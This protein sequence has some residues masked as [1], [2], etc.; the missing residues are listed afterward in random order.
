M[1]DKQ[2]FKLLSFAIIIEIFFALGSNNIMFSIIG[3]CVLLTTAIFFKPFDTLLIITFLLPNQRLL[4]LGSN[5][6]IINVILLIVAVKIF[7]KGFG[8]QKSMKFLNIVVI[9][10]CLFI[11]IYN[12]E[13]FTLMVGFKTILLFYIFNYSIDYSITNQ[14]AIKPIVFFLI[15]VV[16]LGV[17]GFFLGEDLVIG[18]N[19]RFY[20]GEVNNPN[21]TSSQ[22]S[23]GI[24][25]VIL[26]GIFKLVRIK[27]LYVF[28]LVFLFFGLLTQS[29]SFLLSVGL[30]IIIYLL[31]KIDLKYIFKSLLSLSIIFIVFQLS[32]LSTSNF[33]FNLIEA[34]VDRVLD[35]RKGDVSA[36]RT[37]LWLNY[38]NTIWNEPSALMFGK[39]MYNTQEQ[40]GFNQVAHNSII[41]T[42]AAIGVVGLFLFSALFYNFYNR[43]KS[44]ANK[45]SLILYLPL[46]VI[47]SN[48]MTQ[49]SF[50]NMGTIFQFFL[51]VLIFALI[52]Y[53]KSLKI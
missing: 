29:R 39:G 49:H 17:M 27:Y 16:F 28:M 31:Y 3:F 6:S 11:S 15:G 48:S 36:G 22:F 44:Y 21:I 25:L 41:E 45:T 53:Y 10:Y 9:I 26:L 12:M 33:L 47:I 18:A 35:P 51:W 8:M 2:F 34:P 40:Y 30:I 19:E 43:I 23:F 5:I 50:I 32:D 37:I 42:V 7:A 1:I 4:T 14:V 38:V 46:I 13:L 20:G 52:V 24:S